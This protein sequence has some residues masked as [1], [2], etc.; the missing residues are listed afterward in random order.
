MRQ[1]IFAAQGKS[2]VHLLHIGKTGGTALKHALK[3]QAALDHQSKLL[4]DGGSRHEM[5]P[6][7]YVLVLPRYVVNV[8]PHRVTLRDIPEGHGAIF[9]LRD[10]ITRFVSGFYEGQRR[11]Q[12]RYL[13]SWTLDEEMTFKHFQT[14]N[15]LALALS[16]ADDQE[17]A[18]ASRAM[19]TIWHLRRAYTFWL[20]STD[21]VASRLADLFFIGFQE[22]LD[23]DFASLKRKL[24]LHDGVRLPSDDVEAHR[25]PKHLDLGLHDT[26]VENLRSWYEEDSRIFNLCR[27]YAER[28]NHG[29]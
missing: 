5:G 22:S 13:T 10:P 12:P 29:R 1:A 11:G 24:G 17:R 15:Q 20:E 21:Y 28:V 6:D 27:Q 9:F 25:T 8:Q 4:T 23:N 3:E 19:Q 7:H 16:S 26:A 18:A 2:F 14:P